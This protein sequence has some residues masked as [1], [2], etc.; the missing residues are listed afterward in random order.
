MP[1]KQRGNVTKL[2]SPQRLAS[3]WTKMT[4]KHG[5]QTKRTEY[6]NGFFSDVVVVV[7][8]V[9]ALPLVLGKGS[10][11]CALNNNGWP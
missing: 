3:N 11:S 4:I 7:V 2:A 1:S 9:V 5:K 10:P 8:V 6:V